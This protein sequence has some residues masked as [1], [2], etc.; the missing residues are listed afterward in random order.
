M[1][2][3]ELCYTPAIELARRIRD[4]AISPVEVVDH[5]LTRIAEVNPK[6]NCFCFTYA[7]EARATV[8]AAGGA[9]RPRRRGDTREMSG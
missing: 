6:R 4:K 3:L 1:A 9:G 5:G 7:D 2:D 8:T